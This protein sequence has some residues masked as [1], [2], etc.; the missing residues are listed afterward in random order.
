MPSFKNFI[1]IFV[2]VIL[3]VIVLGL[4]IICI[5][6]SPIITS[7]V[8]LLLGV[9]SSYIAVKSYDIL[10]D[11]LSFLLIKSLIFPSWHNW[12][13]CMK[14][15]AKKIDAPQNIDNPNITLSRKLEET[16]IRLYGK[17]FEEARR[18]L[19]DGQGNLRTGLFII[20]GQMFTGRLFFLENELPEHRVD[21]F[22]KKKRADV[23]EVEEKNWLVRGSEKNTLQIAN[24][25]LKRLM[26]LCGKGLFEIGESQRKVVILIGESLTGSELEAVI[27]KIQDKKEGLFSKINHKNLTLILKTNVHYYNKSD[28]NEKILYFDQLNREQAYGMF[29]NDKWNKHLRDK[30]IRNLEKSPY[31]W[32]DSSSNND[33]KEDDIKREKLSNALWGNTF[34]QPHAIKKLYLC[35]NAK[36]DE[37]WRSILKQWKTL[38]DHYHVEF[39]KFLAFLWF[40]FLLRD[41]K[42]QRINMEDT[43]RQIA[44]ALSPNDTTKK[45]WL[46]WAGCVEL[47]W[48]EIFN[49]VQYKEIDS[50]DFNMAFVG[51][52][53]NKL[54]EFEWAAYLFTMVIAPEKYTDEPFADL[55]KIK[56]ISEELK[57][58][59]PYFINVLGGKH[60][61]RSWKEYAKLIA[62]NLINACIKIHRL[63][64]RE[65]KA[66]QIEKIFDNGM[67]YNGIDS[68]RLNEVAT[69]LRQLKEE[70]RK[71]FDFLYYLERNWCY[72]S[73]IERN[74][75]LNCYLKRK[76]DEDYLTAL[77]NALP[78]LLA[79][80]N[81]IFVYDKN[82]DYSFIRFKYIGFFFD[83]STDGQLGRV[84]EIS[85]AQLT[86]DGK[87]R[88]YVAMK[89][90][91]ILF[92]YGKELNDESSNMGSLW[93]DRIYNP[94]VLEHNED[95]I[96]VLASINEIITSF[97]L[98]VSWIKKIDITKTK[99][100][101]ILIKIEKSDKSDFFFENT[102][103]LLVALLIYIFLNTSYDLVSNIIEEKKIHF[104]S[105]KSNDYLN[106]ILQNLIDILQKIKSNFKLNGYAHMIPIETYAYGPYEWSFLSYML[107]FIINKQYV[108]NRNREEFEKLVQQFYMFYI[109]N[110]KC[111]F[112][113]KE[114]LFKSF[115]Y[116]LADD[117]ISVPSFISS[118]SAEKIHNTF[119]EI[120][121]K[122]MISILNPYDMYGLI[123]IFIDIININRKLYMNDN[124][125]FEINEMYL[126]TSR[127][128]INY[129]DYFNRHYSD[130]QKKF[131]YIINYFSLKKL[132]EN[133][134]ELVFQQIEWLYNDRPYDSNAT[135]DIDFFK[136]AL[137]TFDLYELP[138]DPKDLKAIALFFSVIAVIIRDKVKV[139][140]CDEFA[141]D[142]LDVLTVYLD[143]SILYTALVQNIPNHEDML[144]LDAML[145]DLGIDVKKLRKDAFDKTKIIPI[146]YSNL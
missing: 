16:Y 57:N 22:E 76:S 49:N 65:D 86:I 128:M 68:S 45:A 107:K 64:E 117:N 126:A 79:F 21:E 35:E 72:L 91:E 93:K 14:K 50:V 28:I 116:F 55:V 92:N 3:L 100:N 62:D 82:E 5:K 83:L 34:G 90:L 27:L 51:N 104:L 98:D 78:M 48:K 58:H 7:L 132:P 32:F 31:Y 44:T 118:F 89:I 121:N 12:L 75:W 39:K 85:S 143:N 95:A 141:Y 13:F 54:D 80:T 15:F 52:G 108:I 25:L 24:T 11:I 127:C 140:A 136:T 18:Q 23:F 144:I 84:F 106:N 113:I 122:F 101:E 10:D 26:A 29:C 4:F 47:V 53:A 109:Y 102:K 99:I 134:G 133:L 56:D 20:V 6:N 131:Q 105:L 97:Y 9:I 94:V 137:D 129:P 38:C 119:H 36:S 63:D 33:F 40:V 110:E 42:G 88:K 59:L 96:N 71:D 139:S 60:S 46:E 43:L 81:N 115:I 41:D 146:I 2:L 135:N 1:K 138:R 61:N 37:H 30:I 74:E 17:G 120:I 8:S 67:T 19:W 111:N 87:K 130:Y 103:K 125:D 124:I 145:Y 114:Y 69:I 77:F 70:R 123:N 73:A 66:A 142:Y 112:A